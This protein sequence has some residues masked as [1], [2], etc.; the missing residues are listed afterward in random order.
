MP[1]AAVHCHSMSLAVAGHAWF[2]QTVE[3]GVEMAGFCVRGDI[4]RSSML[5]CLRI[6]L[7][8]LGRPAA[9]S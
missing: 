3:R 6:G 7:E 2:R 4:L 1:P 5:A 8:C 9:L